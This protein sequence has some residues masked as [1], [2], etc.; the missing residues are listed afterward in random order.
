MNFATTKFRQT[1]M[2]AG[3]EMG[4]LV[5]KGNQ[6]FTTD[7]KAVEVT[8]A[9]LGTTLQ[10][11]WAT[12]AVVEKALLKYQDRTTE[13]GEAA[14]LA[15]QKAKT[16]TDAIDALKDAVSTSWMNSFRYIF[17][18]LEE[19]SDLWTD[20]ANRII[21]FSDRGDSLRNDILEVFANSGARQ[22]LIDSFYNLFTPFEIVN[23]LWN[24]TIERFLGLTVRADAYEKLGEN[25]KAF[26][27]RIKDS[28]EKVKDFFEEIETQRAIKGIFDGL[29]G[30][31]DIFRQ[32]LRGVKKLIGGVFKGIKPLV[33]PVLRLFGNIG[34]LFRR[35]GV[36]LGASG[37]FD[38]W[39]QNI[40]NGFQPIF[41]IINPI[42]EKIE[43]FNDL[44]IETMANMSA[45]KG[46]DNPLFKDHTANNLT[47]IIN[48]LVSL[49]ML[50]KPLKNGARKLKSGLI[51][52]VF[53]IR[54]VL[55]LMSFQHG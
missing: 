45:R 53:L 8:T 3:V 16:F 43:K 35:L 18:D 46:A 1:L 36:E 42:V 22:D 52:L 9:N 7:K 31:L 10:K 32:A 51:L 25:I 4:T 11:D 54:F 40:L 5:K 2:D 29:V 12:S 33:T 39:S 48:G 50:L 24:N 20:F 37:T 38:K 27:E 49:G 15:A 28:T 17:G 55:S 14:F 30:A 47:K 6:Y 23:D 34:N 41:D 13:F 19:A 21:D 44:I 26:T